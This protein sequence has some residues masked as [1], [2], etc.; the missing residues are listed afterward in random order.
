MQSLRDGCI[1]GT[2]TVRMALDVQHLFMQLPD[3]QR[4]LVQRP[5]VVRILQNFFD[6]NDIRSYTRNSCLLCGESVDTTIQLQHP[7]EQPLGALQVKHHAVVVNS[8]PNAG[9]TAATAAA[10]IQDLI[11]Q[12]SLG[13]AQILQPRP[14]AC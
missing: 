12:L 11:I 8:T 3:I 14:D 4:F 1:R 13:L 9:G 7:F 2:C 6:P 5:D 10:P